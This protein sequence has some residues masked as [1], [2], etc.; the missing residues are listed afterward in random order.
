[1]QMSYTI[2]ESASLIRSEWS[3]EY[4]PLKVQKMV[5]DLMADP[6]IRPGLNYLSDW[7]RLESRPTTNSVKV[8]VNLLEMMIPK[9]GSFKYAI[10][11]RDDVTYGMARMLAGLTTMSSVEVR[12]F[13]E[14]ADAETWLVGEGS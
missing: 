9:L 8:G 11:S 14:L 6:K 2:D 5:V 7:S 3:G 10:V 4:E 12:A 1:V 13:R